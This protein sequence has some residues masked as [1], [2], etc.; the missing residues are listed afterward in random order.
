MDSR[1]HPPAV[2]SIA[3]RRM[4]DVAIQL[5]P[6]RG[7]ESGHLSPGWRQTPGSAP[8]DGGVTDTTSHAG[9]YCL[10]LRSMDFVEH[11]F[12]GMIAKATGDLSFKPKAAS[13][14]GAGPFSVRIEYTDGT[15]D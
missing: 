13:E 10:M 1:L 7:F 4:D 5:I 12:A 15:V 14:I 6:N 2:P 9:S 11:S 3:A 8:L